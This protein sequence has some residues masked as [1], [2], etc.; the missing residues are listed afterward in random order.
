MRLER[1]FADEIIAHAREGRATKEEAEICGVLLGKDGDVSE[2][3]RIK[4][5]D[6]QPR[7]RYVMD[8]HGLF[9]MMRR[10]DETGMELVAIY[11]SHPH[12]RA[13]PSVTDRAN[14]HDDEGR[15]WWPGVVYIICS[16]EHPEQPVLNAFRLFPDR[17]EDEVLE[18]EEE[19]Q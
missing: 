5:I 17:A 15:P 4:N 19:R 1:R 7:V 12:T 16:L 10:L 3:L 18:V 14:A 9:Q 8:P 2:L 13:Y 6:E 11:H